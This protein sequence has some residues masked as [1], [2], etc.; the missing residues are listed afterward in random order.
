MVQA[1]YRNLSASV[2]T[3]E[4]STPVIPLQIGVYQGDPFSVVIFNSVIN[5]LV[6]TLK[7]QTNLVYTLKLNHQINLLQYA[8]DTYLVASSQ[9]ACQYLLNTTNQW[10]LLSGMRAKVPKCHCLATG[11][12]SGKVVD[13]QLVIDSQ[14]MPFIGDKSINFLGMKVK[15][16]SDASS[17]KQELKAR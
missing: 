11:G 6:N 5:T 3:A 15:V 16:P 10:L 17:A 14:P 12:S 1:L 13:P 7:Q 2:I 9:S 8:D 4:W